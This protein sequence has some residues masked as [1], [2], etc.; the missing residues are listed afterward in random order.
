MKEINRYG[1][2]A[3]ATFILINVLFVIYIIVT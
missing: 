2:I 3:K 1:A